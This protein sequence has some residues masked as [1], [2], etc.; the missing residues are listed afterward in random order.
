MK[1]KLSLII[2]TLVCNLI[3]AQVNP[4]KCIASNKSQNELENNPEYVI[5]KQNLA[6]YQ[7]ENK[8][9]KHQTQAIIT[10]PVVVH[11]I[12]RNTH[13]NIGM[14]T[15]ISN[16]QIEDQFRILN[17]D[18]SKTN[19]E[20]PNPPRNNF[21]NNAG[22]P[23]LKF[24]LATID[25]NGN[26]TT[27]ITRF[28]TTK[29]SWDADDDAD[30]EA[31]KQASTGGV[32]NWDP[33]RYLNMWVCNLSN[34]SGGGSTLG[35]AYKPGLQASNESWLDGIVVDYQAFGSIASANASDGRTP[36]HE[37]GHYLGLNHTFCSNGCGDCDNDSFWGGNVDDTPAC[38]DIYFG[39]VNSSTNNNTCNDLN[40]NNSFNTNVLDMDENY[41]SYASNTWM[42]SQGQVDL[43]LSTLNAPTAQGGRRNLKNST[44]SIDCSNLTTSTNNLTT[45][46]NLSIYPNPTKGNLLINTFEKIIS[47]SVCNIVGKKVISNAKINNYQLD[48]NQLSNGIYLIKISTEKGEITKKIILSK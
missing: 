16:A 21:I 28:S 4:K 2:L 8:D 39:T 22:N 7:E 17:E 15:N 18:Y 25:P 11:I 24:C 44:V 3:F 47:I 19:P 36:T 10:I 34:S 12:H 31:M 30:S 27:G 33:L 14:G 1:K 40:Y 32:N 46:I 41:M 23:Q 13:T 43:M 5:M 29:L 42:F 45:N 9:I 37:I 26:P 6:N 20:F 48:L 35:Y 38:S